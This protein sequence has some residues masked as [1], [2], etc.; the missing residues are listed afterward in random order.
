MRTSSFLV[1]AV[2]VIGG[3][4][5][6]VLFLAG[7]RQTPDRPDAQ[8]DSFEEEIQPQDEAAET[9]Q[10]APPGVAE[11][12]PE[13]AETA[14]TR[15]PEA[16]LLPDP[17]D[18]RLRW[19]KRWLYMP[20]NL[21]VNENL[22]KL[23]D[24]MRRAVDAGYNGVLFTD[25]KT[26]TWWQL[27]YADR[28]KENAGKLR[29]MADEF[30][31]E[32][33][34][35]VFP[36]GY[37][38]SLL[39][40]DVNLASAIPVKDAPLVAGNGVLKPEPT[41]NL[42]NGSFEE[43]RD[44][45]ALRYSFQDNVGESSFIDREMV[46]HGEVSLRFEDVGKVNQHGH[47]RIS[48]T[49]K[50]QPWQQYRFRAWMKTENLTASQVKM[51]VLAG[52]R[53]LQHQYLVI[54]TGGR[55]RHVGSFRNVT[56]DWVEQSVTFNSLDNS[57]VRIYVG[58]WGGK[59][60]KIWWDNLRVEDAP[61]L[62]LLRRDS[63]P[64]VIRG[65][66]GTVYEEGRDFE[67]VEDPQLG[68]K[69]WPGQ[70]N[71][72][73]DPP[74]IRLTPGSRIAGGQ[75]VFLSCCHTTMVHAAQMNCSMSEPKVFDLCRLQMKKT[76]EALNPDGFFMS[77]D[78]IRVA[79]WEPNQVE[80]FETSGELFAFNIRRCFDIAHAEGGSKPVYLWSDM[81]DPNHNAHENFYL[82]NNTIAGSW[83]GLDRRI[84]IMKWGGG[85][86]ARPGLEFFAGR[87]HR[88][89]IAGYYDGNVKSNHRMWM[90][91][92]EGIP[93]IIGAMYTQWGSGYG[94]MEE[95]AE[96]WWGGRDGAGEIDAALDD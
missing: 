86:L 75:K 58:T 8:Q 14:Q 90:E 68:N 17:D 34:V 89:M 47:G 41:V 15:E 36:F 28:W 76:V 80:R 88:Q 65:E 10:E 77:H 37:A 13:A 61:T 60:G 49:I 93:G 9:P 54:K 55:E 63:L 43:H 26:F 22:P 70:Y 27:D 33:N 56:T 25:Y 81:Y 19:R 53:T 4:V 64:F 51:L 66:D 67:R 30:G 31:L 39:W 79:G 21:Y 45:R 16:P 32:L 62:N 42:L 6:G 72:R 5:L 2:V 12:T 7:E 94:K 74:E 11:P 91:A 71:T 18:P 20:T 57:E 78:E 46:K 83:E 23:R 44:N 87:G 50:V 48:Q 73:H 95:F 92:A 52:N 82:V 3:V 59:T 29:E 35:C 69:P 84:I 24:L 1:L 96:T 40:H 85:K 38:S